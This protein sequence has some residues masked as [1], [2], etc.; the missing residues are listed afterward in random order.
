MKKI[1]AKNFL[2]WQLQLE[3]E[4]YLLTVTS[5]HRG[6]EN[7][8]EKTVMEKGEDA[9]KTVRHTHHCPTCEEISSGKQY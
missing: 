7:N 9:Q 5:Q 4:I 2:L 8:A 1:A 6:G 3:E